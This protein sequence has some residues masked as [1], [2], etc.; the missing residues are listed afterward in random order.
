MLDE[1]LRVLGRRIH[2]LELNL[3]N[4]KEQKEKAML[5]RDSLKHDI[6][7]TQSNQDS[8]RQEIEDEMR[9]RI[10]DKER[11]IRKLRD[12]I[13]QS[14][15]QHAMELE[16]LKTS[17]KNDLEMIQEKVQAALAKKKEII[18]ALHDELKLKDLQV[19]KL[20]EMLEKQRRELLK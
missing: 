15:H 12:G 20:K 18:D 14:E 10:E 8:V 19:V 3:E 11:E 6:A 2:E 1:N 5:E 17:N 9:L 13:Q 7:R 16:Q 4:E